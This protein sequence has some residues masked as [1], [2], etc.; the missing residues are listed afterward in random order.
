MIYQKFFFK[1]ILFFL[2]LFFILQFIFLFYPLEIFSEI[3]QSSPDKIHF[4]KNSKSYFDANLSKLEINQIPIFP[5]VIDIEID[6]TNNLIYAVYSKDIYIFNS[7]TND[8]VGHIASDGFTWKIANNPEINRLYVANVKIINNT[9]TFVISV[10]DSNTTK[11][12]DETIIPTGYFN[13]M[14]L[15]LKTNTL[16]LSDYSNGNIYSLDYKNKQPVINTIKIPKVIKLDVNSINH[17][18]YSLISET[19][20]ISLIE[21]NL[22][23]HKNIS[24]ARTPNDLAINPKTNMMYV[25]NNDN[26]R[27]SVIDS[28]TDKVN[29][30]I[31]LS[32]EGKF[33]PFDKSLAIDSTTNLIYLTSYKSIFV[34]DDKTNELLLEI[35]VGFGVLEVDINPNKNLIYVT[36]KNEG[37]IHIFNGTLDNIMKAVQNVIQNK[38]HSV[39]AKNFGIN[40]IPSPKEIT[41][42]HKT[43]KIYTIDDSSGKIFVI[44]ER[45]E[46]ILDQLYIVNSPS[47]LA[48]NTEN[49]IIF[50]LDDNKIYSLDGNT[51]R[52]KNQSFNVSN[53]SNEPIDITINEEKNIL[54]ITYSPKNSFEKS[55]LYVI[56]AKDNEIIDS[57]SFSG[58]GNIAIDVKGNLIYLQETNKITILNQLQNGTINKNRDNIFIDGITDF[59]FDSLNKNLHIISDNK[60]YY[61]MDVY[62]D[63]ITK[64][65]LNYSPY[66]INIDPLNN[67]GYILNFPFD[68]FTLIN[69]LNKPNIMNINLHIP[70]IGTYDDLVINPKTNKIFITSAESGMISVLNETSN[71]LTIGITYSVNPPNLG[72]I[73]CNK[74][75]ITD[76]SF[77]KYDKSTT[78]ECEAKPNSGALFSSW[79]GD[80]NLTKPSN[81]K[82][83]LEASQYGNI[84]ANFKEEPVAIDFKIPFDTMLQIFFIVIAA[85]IGWLIP[86]IF[87][88]INNLRFRTKRNQYLEM[89]NNAR[90]T[91]A[92]KGVYRGILNDFAQNNL[93]S[94]NYK[95]LNEIIKEK[96]ERL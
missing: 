36:D 43:G 90:D 68:S 96:L 65:S 48:V 91:D 64:K 71:K 3:S 53:S 80:F 86:S 78:I 47:K 77:K 16:Y 59:E 92:L 34:I 74:E 8:R 33:T 56:D 21:S 38:K 44:D 11:V 37:I 58:G 42:N 88:G 15:D 60:T 94:L 51:N 89:I 63:N 40:V 24:V 50:I 10:I 67:R 79:S 27:I 95:Y 25:V 57:F 83:N 85:I 6:S 22:T 23:H 41:V 35:P 2:S 39:D 30:T 52:I 49:N 32:L 28:Q 61:V 5:N 84:T 81:H 75:K 12:I 70:F 31:S 9:N 62:T 1:K 93:N 13:D 55:I 54:Y 66:K 17:K 72:F 82:L 19:S 46:K 20:N 76:I 4:L 87:N 69:N 73:E 7:I 45:T 14:S 29:K 18:I 26:N